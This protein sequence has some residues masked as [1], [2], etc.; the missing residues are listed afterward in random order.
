MISMRKKEFFIS[1]LS[2]F[3]LIPKNDFSFRPVLL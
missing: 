3:N 1:D 2:S